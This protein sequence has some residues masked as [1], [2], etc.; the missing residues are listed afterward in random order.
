MRRIE[1]SLA[2]LHDSLYVAIYPKVS[3]MLDKTLSATSAR[4]IFH[5]E[6]AQVNTLSS[7]SQERKALL[8]ISRYWMLLLCMALCGVGLNIGCVER[9][10]TLNFVVTSV[11][12]E[13]PSPGD[14]IVFKE[15]VLVLH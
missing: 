3:L 14:E 6:V 13:S 11:S 5:S 9:D 4:L 1:L 7:T 15:E 2:A 8:D 12:P 10:S